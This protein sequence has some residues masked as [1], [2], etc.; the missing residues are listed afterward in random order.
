VKVRL[1]VVGRVKGSLARA[2]SD[3]EARASRYWKLDIDEVEGGAPGGR[4]DP[5]AVKEAEAERLLTRLPA[6]AR[7]VALTREGQGMPSR[8][9]AAMLA[10]AALHARDVAFVVGG[11]WGLHAS[12]LERS[13]AQLS[14]SEMTL[15]HEL[16]RVVLAEQ[17]YRA[18]TLQRGEPY[19]KGP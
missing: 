1:V 3:Y 9:L 17:L 8:A 5:E 12:V 16:V 13:D 18:G 19:H 7:V 11:A 10:D 15:P 6:Y 14:L 2:V 4:D